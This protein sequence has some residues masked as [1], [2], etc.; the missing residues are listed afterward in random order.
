[1]DL[2][3][4]SQACNESDKTAKHFPTYCLLL[5]AS[6]PLHTQAEAG[7]VWMALLALWWGLT[8]RK[9]G[10]RHPTLTVETPAWFGCSAEAC[11]V[12]KA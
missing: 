12:P 10:R 4:Q 6:M 1:M 3:I 2:L 11:D 7:P 5:A 9:Q 8:A